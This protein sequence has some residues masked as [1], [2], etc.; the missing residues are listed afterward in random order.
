MENSVHD[1]TE[2]LCRNLTGDTDSD[3]KRLAGEGQKHIQRQ[4]HPLVREGV[5]QKQD[6]NCQRV[7]HI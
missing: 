6:R 4:A 5:P 2:P 7:L 3:P 1:L